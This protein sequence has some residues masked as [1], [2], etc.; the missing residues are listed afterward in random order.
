MIDYSKFQEALNLID[1]VGWRKGGAFGGPIGDAE[2]GTCV[3]GAIA[4]VVSGDRLACYSVDHPDADGY[5]EWQKVKPY[6]NVFAEHVDA[7]EAISLDS[8]VIGW[9]DSRG[10]KEEEVRAALSELAAKGS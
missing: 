8:R 6:F 7:P 4:Y 1:T 5:D 9:N 10:R 2:S 3:G